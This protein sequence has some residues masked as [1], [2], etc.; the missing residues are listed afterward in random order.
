MC[1][2]MQSEGD[3]A[4]VLRMQITLRQQE[5]SEKHVFRKNMSRGSESLAKDIAQQ[6]VVAIDL[7]VHRV[8]TD[9]VVNNLDEGLRKRMQFL[10][11]N[12]RCGHEL[13]EREEIILGVGDIDRA[14][15]PAERAQQD[16]R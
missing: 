6:V 16:F 8:G 7:Q 15:I 3:P 14:L 10:R 4:G 1:S 5:P 11:C 2:L 13:Q 12:I 9:L